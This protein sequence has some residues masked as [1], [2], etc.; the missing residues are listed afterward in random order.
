MT[1]SHLMSRRC[2]IPL[3]DSDSYSRPWLVAAAAGAPTAMLWY[4][5]VLNLHFTLPLALVLGALLAAGCHAATTPERPPEW[6]LGLPFP[7]GAAA[8]A[9]VGFAASAMW[10]DTIAGVPL[11]PPILLYPVKSTFEVPGSLFWQL[12]LYKVC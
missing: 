5:Q 2:S 8:V 6:S 3:V 4:F 1:G 11:H 7:V 10:I 9:V 12:S